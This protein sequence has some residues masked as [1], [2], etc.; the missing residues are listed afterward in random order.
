MD[1]R[2][3][4]SSRIAREQPAIDLAPDDVYTV[5]SAERRRY[6]LLILDENV[7]GKLPLSDLS[8]QVATRE[9]GTDRSGASTDSI[10]STYVSLYQSHLPVL[11]RH[12]AV[13][14]D[15]E[16][17]LICESNSVSGLA[18]LIREIDDRTRS[19]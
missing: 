2:R 8:R 10:Q 17:N 19:D 4:L 1:L 18:T 15:Q 14:W 7:P 9:T 3:Y 16:M 12:G 13:E 11:D 6:V 5:L